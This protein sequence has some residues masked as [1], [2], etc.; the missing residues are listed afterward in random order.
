M[1]CFFL[2]R[3]GKHSD[4]SVSFGL[5]YIERKGGLAELNLLVQKRS[6]KWEGFV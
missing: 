1:F 6:L 5:I 4:L 2:A 3:G